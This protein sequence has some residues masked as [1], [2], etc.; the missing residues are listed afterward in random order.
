M[1][2]SQGHPFRKFCPGDLFFQFSGMSRNN[3]DKFLMVMPCAHFQEFLKLVF[4]ICLGRSMLCKPDR[5]MMVKNKEQYQ[6]KPA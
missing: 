1:L 3:S 5:R 2:F 4:A 6:G